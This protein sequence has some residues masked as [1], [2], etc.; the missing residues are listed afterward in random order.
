M[1]IRR[2][3]LFYSDVMVR[4]EYPGYI[5]RDWHDDNVNIEIYKGNLE[6]LKQYPSEFA[7]FSYYRTSAH[8]AG[9]PSFKKWL[10]DSVF[11]ATYKPPTNLIGL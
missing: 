2:K 1:D 9:H 6:L 8:K 7:A 3:S 10:M 11:N 4:G 5:L